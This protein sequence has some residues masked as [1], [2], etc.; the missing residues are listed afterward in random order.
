[1]F[2]SWR[3]AATACGIVWLALTGAPAL[4]D[5]Q[6]PTTSPITVGSK[7]LPFDIILER[8][9]TGGRLPTLQGYAAGR[10]GNL[11]VLVGGRTNGLHNFTNDPLQNF[12]PRAQS[13]RIWVIDTTTWR[14]W[15]RSLYNS[16]LGLDQGDQLGSFASQSVQKGNTLYIVGGYGYSRKRKQF[17]TFPVMTALD[18][19]AIVKWVRQPDRSPKLSTLI[20]Q[21]QDETLR[22]TGGQMKLLGRRA[23]LAFG[24]DF[25]GGYGDPNVV[26]T[27][28]GQI[29]SF[30]IV[31]D[32][33]RLAI[34]K[35]LRS[36]AKPDLENYRR[37][38]Y[39][40]GS[41][42]DG[43]EE[44]AVALAGVFTETN[45]A[46]T[47]PVEID[48]KG[49]PFQRDPKAA[50]TF[51]QGM[52]IYDCA[53][54]GIYDANAGASHNV[55]FGGISYLTYD[56]GQKKFIADDN[57]PFTSQ[58]TDVVRDRHDRYKQYLLP[59]TFPKVS[60]PDV[61]SY[62]LGAE[63]RVFLKPGVP[64]RGDD[65]VDLKTLQRRAGKRNEIGWIFG[66]IAATQPNFGPS[67]A[68]NELFRIVLREK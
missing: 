28:T 29:R 47:V 53:V 65:L 8:V 32:G 7:D 24:Q 27:Y 9:D 26:Q 19:P 5:N 56:Y 61:D 42:I 59:T 60:G 50:S 10:Y 41:I 2:K 44:K 31:D 17:E 57:F 39:T 20:R 22:V 14:A 12:P 23:I 30:E 66:G 52:N 13:R 54:L 34:A 58:V 43:R 45:G 18:L 3:R 1:M 21:V 36:P 48:R 37:R 68:S 67:V 4:A 15:S 51:K 16:G 64:V 49:R 11:W 6:T 35:V 33:K 25:A 55:L 63:A 40:L 46:F 62:L 38:D